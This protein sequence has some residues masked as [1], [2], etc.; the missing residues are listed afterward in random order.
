M[1]SAATHTHSAISRKYFVAVLMAGTA[2]AGLVAVTPPQASAELV[3]P[4]AQERNVTLIVSSLLRKEHLS[5]RQLDDEISQRAIKMFLEQLD[6]FKI[7]FTQADVN[8]FMKYRNSVDDFVKRGDIA[9][10]YKIANR[11]LKRVDEQLANVKK[12]VRSNH[13]FTLDEKL[14]TDLDELQY[15]RDADEMSERW[16]KRIKYELLV[17]K[18]TDDMTYEEAQDK[19]IRLYSSLGKRKHQMD[20]DELLEMFL[21]SVTSSFDPHST[22]MSPSNLENFNINMRLNLDG[23]GAALRPE[24]GFTVV[25]K[26]IPG[27]AADK[28]GKLKPEDKIVSVGQ[29]DDGDMVDIID[30]KLNDVVKM[31][32][33]HAGTVVRLGV[34]P[35]GET[36]T[37]EYKITRARIQ[38]KDSE[39][40][41]DVIELEPPKPATSEVIESETNGKYKVG[42]INLPSF[43]MDMNAAR[44]GATNFKSTTRDVSRILEDFK[45]KSVDV[46]VL[47]LR[48][49][50][51]GSLT[52]AIN[53]T[54]LFIDYGPV[55]QVKDADGRV[56]HYDDLERGMKWNRPLVV[57]TNRFSAS[58]SEILAG[59]IKDY[60]RGIVV[61]DDS[62]HGKGTVQSLLDLGQQLY[63]TPDPPNYGALKI[64]MQQFYRPSGESTQKRGVLANV[65]LPSMTSQFDKGEAELDYAID[66]DRVNAAAFSKC[67]MVTP[68]MIGELKSRSDKRRQASEEFGK[69]AKKIARYQEQ[70]NRKYVTLNEAQ[71]LKE[72]EELDA[73]REE[74]KLI[75][76]QMDPGNKP[77]IDRNFYFD[78]V[79][80]ISLDY[81]QL[82]EQQRLVKLN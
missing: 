54:G 58:A 28:H 64:T 77:V 71:F 12:I 19:V 60:H 26:V 9:V 68:E 8:E 22:Y 78:E 70:K 4:G 23:I 74:E 76:D 73:E 33:G 5:K 2:V 49:N 69:L 13:D 61:G 31:I 55:V 7:F 62:T 21:T 59:A 82:L 65:V 79:L 37:E 30:M 63:H 48:N 3:A 27:G 53:L 41:S 32:R 42:V 11:Y 67:D 35:S 6:P 36:A 75:E 47:D 57:I 52:E 29:G 51:G 43:Y 66:F 39:A 10:A 81:V 24:D 16:R 56:Q 20:S 18:N 72:R 25:Q 46:V 17:R 15:A 34:I 50:G 1:T 14:E 80:D 44:T 45:T 38:L 40:R